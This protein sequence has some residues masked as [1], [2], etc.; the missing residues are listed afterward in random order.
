MN[1]TSTP[2]AEKGCQAQGG[3]FLSDEDAFDVDFA[4]N[5]NSEDILNDVGGIA[6]GGVTAGG[7]QN[8]T[9]NQIIKE[10]SAPGSEVMTTM[11]QPDGGS[12]HN[13]D[14]MQI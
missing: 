10:A 11:R 13:V 8:Q 6:S 2:S 7:D 9:F 3:S 14:D 1:R 4:L 5:L 12:G